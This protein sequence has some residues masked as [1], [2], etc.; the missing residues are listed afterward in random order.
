M[1]TNN[2]IL[3]IEDDLVLRDNIKQLL[4]NENF[5]VEIAENGRIGIEKVHSFKPDLIISDIMMPEMDGFKFLEEVIKDYK[6]ASIPVIFLTAKNDIENLRKGMSLGADDYIFK[7]FNI[8]DLINS[9]QVRLKKKEA[10]DKKFNESK[11]QI[12]SKMHHDLRTP[13]MP[14][15]GY[16]SII[17]DLNDLS[18]IKSLAKVIHKSGEK[19]YNRIDKL[20]IFNQLLLNENDF[21]LEKEIV[22]KIDKDV[23]L[24]FLK[25]QSE[26]STE[27]YRIIYDIESGEVKINRKNL[28]II[29]KELVENSLKFSSK[30]NKVFIKGFNT[31]CYYIFEIID[32]GKGFREEEIKNIS[33]FTKFGDNQI[34]TPGL[35]L[36]LAIVKKISELNNIRFEIERFNN[37]FT[38]CSL[39]IP[40]TS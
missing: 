16:S 1:V 13:L 23:I 7:P 11:H 5:C 39:I 19:L 25:S 32:K 33:S 27:L 31:N 21:K 26:I 8:D 3:I 17:D 28:Q 6:T 40:L 24:S 35:G 18:E 2:K 30:D 10:S 38:I 15:L 12:L 14:I 9:I 37:E 36:G 20:L 34:G 22:T 4:E 29:L